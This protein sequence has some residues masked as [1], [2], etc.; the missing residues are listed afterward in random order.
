MDIA[1]PSIEVDSIAAGAG[2]DEK[3]VLG[4]AAPAAATALV[5]AQM[6]LMQEPG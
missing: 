6:D 2:V 3:L 4:A 1:E 5:C